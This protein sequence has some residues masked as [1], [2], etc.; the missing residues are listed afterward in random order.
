MGYRDYI[1][2]QKKYIETKKEARRKSERTKPYGD[3]PPQE[4]SRWW[5]IGIFALILLPLFFSYFTAPLPVQAEKDTLTLAIVSSE[6]E[7][8]Q[9]KNWL[10]G[11]I[12]A[13]NLLWNIAHYNAWQE[14]EYQLRFGPLPDLLL[15]DRSLAERYYQEGSLAPLRE[16]QGPPNFSDFFFSLWPSRPFQKTMGLAIPSR[17]RVEQARH[18]CTIIEYFAPAF[19]P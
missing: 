12:T 15:I 16:R 3:P 8:V 13:N 5:L 2:A 10:E 6:P 17:G 4:P 1:D 9:L 7:F 14:L 11:E 18:L 19:R